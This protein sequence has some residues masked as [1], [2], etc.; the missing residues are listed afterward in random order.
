[1]AQIAGWGML[2]VPIAD[3]SDIDRP[4]TWEDFVHRVVWRTADEA[5]A[6]AESEWMNYHRE[7]KGDDPDGDSWLWGQPPKWDLEDDVWVAYN[8]EA[9]SVFVV[10]SVHYFEKETKDG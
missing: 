5:K 2:E 6:Y 9:D 4:E 3:W 10:F 1:M 7:E 8:H